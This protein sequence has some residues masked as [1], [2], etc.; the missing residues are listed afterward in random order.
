MAFA[1]RMTTS[2]CDLGC[3]NFKARFVPSAKR[4]SARIAAKGVGSRGAR[5]PAATA[6]DGQATDE[7][8]ASFGWASGGEACAAGLPFLRS[9]SHCMTT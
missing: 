5:Q 3:A 6:R 9:S 4:V 2:G 7:L 8:A 1:L